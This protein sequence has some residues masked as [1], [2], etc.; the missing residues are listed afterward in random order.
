MI[1]AISANAKIHLMGYASSLGTLCAETALGPEHFS[2]SSSFQAIQALIGSI[3]YLKPEPKSEGLNRSLL[4]QN[5]S[6]RLAEKT[7]LFSRKHQPF[8]TIGGDHTCAIGTWS[9]VSEG[10]REKGELGLIWF[11]AHMDS[12]T[13][14]T[15]QSGNIHGMPLAVLLGYGDPLLTQVQSPQPKIKPENLCLIGVRSFENDEAELL[16]NL[17]VRIF[18]IE[19]IL[20]RGITAVLAEALSIATKNTAGFGISLDLDVFD[21]TEVPGV[22]T[23]APQGLSSAPLINALKAW[24]NHPLLLGLE[25]AEFTP[26]MDQDQ[27]TEKIMVNIIEAIFGK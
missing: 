17:K 15:T 27:K 10:I 2:H 25:I 12:H 11:D 13:P 9:G 24:N 16:N 19:E 1:M 7:E 4:I 3:E 18:L 6:A 8:V 14:E 20:D 23:P 21:P 22:G 26:A 5:I